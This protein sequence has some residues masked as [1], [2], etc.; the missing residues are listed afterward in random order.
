MKNN[1]IIRIIKKFKG[2]LMLILLLFLLGY[3]ITENKKLK[4]EN[5]ILNDSIEMNF[6]KHDSLIKVLDTITTKYDSLSELND[7]LIKKN[8]LYNFLNKIAFRESS[9]DQFEENDYGMLG[10][11][12]FNPQTLSFLGY[13]VGK[14]EYLNS[15]HIQNDAMISYLKFNKKVLK[16][17]IDTYDGKYHKGVY[18]TASGLLAGAHLTGAGGV[19]EFFDDGD[20]YKEHDGNNIHVSEY[21]EEFSGYEIMCFL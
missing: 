5:V 2:V 3:S 12:Q 7:D 11:Y 18:I 15:V 20:K 13:K 10:L 21:I 16:K 9:G 4:N 6:L 8:D 1:L 19:M 14:Y 17:Y